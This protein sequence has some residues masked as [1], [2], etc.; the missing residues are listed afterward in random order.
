[1]ILPVPHLKQQNWG[2]CLVACVG[3]VLAYLGI[4]VNYNQLCELLEVRSGIGTPAYKVQNLTQLGL[5]IIYQQGTIVELYHYIN[6]NIPCIA[7]VKTIELP[8]WTEST[9]HAV[10]VVGFDEQYIYLNDPEFEV[11]PWRVSKGD[12]DLAWLERDEYY[13]VLIPS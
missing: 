13:V 10:V 7:L 8:Y 12:F 3:M 5:H 9:D 4:S 6:N 1:M 2:E 11:A